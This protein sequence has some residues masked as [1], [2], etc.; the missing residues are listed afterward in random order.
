MT[1]PG[2]GVGVGPTHS[3]DRVGPTRT[4]CLQ[5]VQKAGVFV[6][7]ASLFGTVSILPFLKKSCQFAQ[8]LIV[9]VQSSVHVNLCLSKVSCELAYPLET[10]ARSAMIFESLTAP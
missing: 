1:H 7:S 10:P 2:Q 9:P 8:I 3:W 6:Q 4:S 5:Q